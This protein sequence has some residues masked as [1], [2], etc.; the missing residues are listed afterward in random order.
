MRK[1][2]ILL[3]V[4]G[5]AW[6]AFAFQLRTTVFTESQTIGIG[7]SPYRTP[8]VEV[9][10]IGLMENRRIHLMMAG[11][12]VLVGVI[13]IGFGTVSA[14]TKAHGIK[15]CP[16][17]AEQIQR[18][19]IKCRHCNADIPLAFQQKSD[20]VV[21]KP[22]AGIKA[23]LSRN[24]KALTVGL[25]L[26]VVPILLLLGVWTLYFP[27][28]V[29][30]DHW[31]CMKRSPSHVD[32]T[33]AW[34]ESMK[35]CMGVKRHGLKAPAIAEVLAEN[36]KLRVRA[37]EAKAGMAERAAKRKL[38]E[39]EQHPTNLP[40]WLDKESKRVF[41]EVDIALD[42]ANMATIDSVEPMTNTNWISL[43]LST[44]NWE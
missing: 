10:N 28:T 23:L 16:F 39:A 5:L 19:A 42:G 44:K 26:K 27:T 22:F 12:T 1:L 25:I 4:V 15:R 43:Y 34:G 17:C 30:I 33:E 38:A 35:Q 14:T 6:L 13:F 2:G 7:P 9:S 24:K 21:E 3:T 20:L 31:V 40:D 41:K 29:E 37:L 32:N 36:E 8:S 11:L 18:G